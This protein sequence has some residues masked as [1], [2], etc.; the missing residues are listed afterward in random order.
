VV[1]LGIE[2]SCDETAAAVVRGPGE[3]GVE[4]LAS[5]VASQDDLHA[6]FGGIVPEVASRRHVEMIVPVVREAMQ[7]A[8]ARWDDLDAIAVTVGPGLIGSLVVGVAA[9]KGLAAARDLPLVGVHHLEGHIYG[10]AVGQALPLPAVYLVASGGHSHLVMMREHG[11][12]E[13]LGRTRDDAP[14]E[15]FDKGARLL[16]LPYPGGPLLAELADSYSGRVEPL[17]RARIAHSF[18]FSFSG[19]KSALA[20]MVQEADLDDEGRSRVAAAYQESIVLS[21]AERAA[22]AAEETGYLPVVVVGGVARNRRLRELLSERAQAGGLRVVFPEA[23]LCT[24]NGA[25]VAAAGAYKFAFS[26]GS[27]P[28]VDCAANLP[29]CSWAKKSSD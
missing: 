18:D 10:A 7:R 5:V 6:H 20:R 14:G 11:E 28:D 22:E 15:A 9:A 13:V 19:V 3:A 23:D 16:G 1:I 26:G 2:T 27:G 4:L 17:P 21:L 24:D 8:G 29:L 25:M 12:Y